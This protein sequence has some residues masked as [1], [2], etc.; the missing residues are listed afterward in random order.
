MIAKNSTL[1]TPITAAEREKYASIFRVHQPVNGIMDAETAR[2]VF[3]KSKLP[4]DTL[5]QIW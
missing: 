3:L 1:D 5:S 4:V 2:N